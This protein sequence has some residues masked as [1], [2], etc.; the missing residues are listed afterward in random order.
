M[1]VSGRAQED[2][3]DLHQGVEPA[4]GVRDKHARRIKA[5][6]EEFLAE[7][8]F[9]VTAQELEV[10]EEWVALRN[11]IQAELTDIFGRIELRHIRE[12]RAK[13]AT[14]GNRFER[15]TAVDNALH[16]CIGVFSTFV[17]PAHNVVHNQ[18]VNAFVYKRIL[19]IDVIQ[20]LDRKARVA[21]DQ[22]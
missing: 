11:D 15:G 12:I 16:E 14:S 2:G 9:Q 3:A 6:R 1:F 8:V 19:K 13:H 5:E 7:I 4:Y 10:R 18:P 22:G 17:Q 20:H 21:F